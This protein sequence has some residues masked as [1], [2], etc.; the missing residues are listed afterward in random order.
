MSEVVPVQMRAGLV[1][2]HAVLLV[3]GYCLQGWVGFG[4]YFWTSGELRGYAKCGLFTDN[5]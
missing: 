2:I 1:D 4:F 5:R 3:F